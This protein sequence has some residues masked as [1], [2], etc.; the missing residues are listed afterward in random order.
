M[1]AIALSPNGVD[2]YNLTGR[3]DVV[4]AATIDGVVTLH[5][6]NN[7]WEIVEHGLR[8]R[9]VSSLLIGQD[10]AYAGTHD[11]GIFRRL[12]DGPGE[13]FS[14][15]LTVTNVYSLNWRMH[16]GVR[17]IY[18][19]TEP[20]HLYRYREAEDGWRELRGV[21]SIPSRGVWWFPAA[22]NIAHVKHVDF[23]PSIS[24]RFLVSIEQGALLVT[25]DDGNSFR[26]IAFQDDTYIADND[27]HRCVI[28]PFSPD[29]M[30]LTGGDGVT[31]TLDGGQTWRHMTTRKMRI[32]YPDQAFLS[33]EESGV[34]YIA[35]ASAKPGAWRVSGDADAAV[36]R[37]RDRGLSWEVLSLPPIRGNIEAMTL[38]SW[39]N[40]FGFFVGTTDGEIFESIDRGDT[41]TLLTPLIPA[42][43]KCIHFTNI[44]KGRGVA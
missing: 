2:A 7:A 35:G 44:L 32:G 11:D 23:H 33:P 24:S 12:N 31:R 41:W 26:Q 1:N 18:A 20:A 19:G 13:P 37:S 5:Y 25:D 8:G 3:P 22:P 42:I 4:H 28:S 43:S 38:A 14:D 36:A 6:L 17:E 27:L 34:L 9:H 21:Q 30:Y 39:P 10:I 15:G 16:D 29:E 40:G